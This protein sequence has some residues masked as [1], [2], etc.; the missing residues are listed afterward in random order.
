MVECCDCSSKF[1]VCH[2][3]AVD[4]GWLM[5]WY[6]LASFLA[7]FEASHDSSKSVSL[8]VGGSQPH[9]LSPA[10]HLPQNVV[11]VDED[12][13]FRYSLTP[14]RGGTRHWTYFDIRSN[15]SIVRV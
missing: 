2:A 8:N 11:L 9:P 1:I 7:I 13:N 12:I 3:L 4:S 15:V 10:T 5:M 6:A 14:I